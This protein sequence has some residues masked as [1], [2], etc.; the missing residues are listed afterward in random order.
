MK[1][2]TGPEVALQ[3]GIQVKEERATLTGDQEPDRV[4]KESAVPM[5]RDGIHA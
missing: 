5:W 1:G 3:M 4:K 2:T